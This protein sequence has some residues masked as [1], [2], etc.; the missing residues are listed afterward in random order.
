MTKKKNDR[1]AKGATL[2]SLRGPKGDIK[3]TFKSKE[4]RN[5]RTETKL[6]PIEI[7]G[8]DLENLD[9]VIN[10]L[11][12]SGISTSAYKNRYII[13]R[14][15]ARIGRLKL[16]TYKEYLDYLKK[17]PEEIKALE[18]ALSINVTRFFRNAETYK[19]I[20]D[21]ILPSLIQ[22]NTA[23][24]I[25]KIKIWSAGCAVGAEPYSIAILCRATKFLNHDIS[26]IATDLNDELLAIAQ[27]GVYSSQYLA[28]VTSKVALN[29]FFLDRNNNYRVKPFIKKMVEFQRL[30]LTKEA[31]PKNLDMIIC[32]NVLIYF[33]SSMQYQVIDKFHKS[34]KI[35]GY[36]ILGRAETLRV[37]WKKIF[38]VVSAKHRV[39]R[40]FNLEDIKTA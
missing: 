11:S 23:S 10:Y 28:E 4:K 38:E 12:L 19:F 9:P 17:N 37:E 6:S 7:K 24:G 21:S 31:Y 22:D 15:R 40:K 13:R 2:S 32:R 26:I 18:E 29:N 1:V 33:D 5:K 16:R 39:Y 20:G 14:T 34:L 8:R 35:R 30:D 27:N 3:K 36:L 25:A